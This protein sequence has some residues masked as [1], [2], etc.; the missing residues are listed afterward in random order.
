MLLHSQLRPPTPP[1]PSASISISPSSIISG[2]GSATLSWSA[3]GYYNSLSVTGVSNPAGSGSIAVSP[4]T[5]CI[6][7]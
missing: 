7:Y 3:S 6:L 1:A 5:T 2:Q 4:G